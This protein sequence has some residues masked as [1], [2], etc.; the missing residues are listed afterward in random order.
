MPL[1]GLYGMLRIRI[2]QGTQIIMNTKLT[3]VTGNKRKALEIGQILGCEV[4]AKAL[5]IQEIQSLDVVYVARH[6]AAQA[7]EQLGCPVLVDDTGMVIEALNGL[8]G[9][10]VV[11]FLDAVGPAGILQMIAHQENRRARVSTCIGYADSTGVYTFLGEVSGSIPSELLGENGFGY[12]PIFIPDGADVTYAQMSDEQKNANS[13]RG[14][15]L[16]ALRRFLDE[17][18]P[19]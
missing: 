1:L 9:A 5:E 14:I 18:K 11:W 17:R 8:P 2:R 6:K 13:M 4:E 7:F 3:V 16:A 12:D 19:S 10:L 15:A